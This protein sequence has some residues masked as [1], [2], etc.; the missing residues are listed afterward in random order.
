MESKKI[1]KNSNLVSLAGGIQ[2]L[3]NGRGSQGYCDDIW[4]CHRNHTHFVTKWKWGFKN[5]RHNF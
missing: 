4:F 3:R 2:K 5:A 1:N